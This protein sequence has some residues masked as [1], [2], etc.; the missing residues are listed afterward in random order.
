VRAWLGAWTLVVPVLVAACE[1]GP[2]P[3]AGS[4]RPQVVASFYPLAFAV[5]SVAHGRASVTDLTPAGVEP[6]D[7][8][9]TSG[10]VIAVSEADLLVYV[11]SGF[12]PAVE[13]LA[14]GM[15]DRA[16]DV[17]ASQGP[18]TVP[19]SDLAADPHV[20]LD[21]IRM[22][23]ITQ[24][25]ADRLATIDSAAAAAYRAHRDELGARLQALDREFRRGLA[26]CAQREIVTSHEAF[27]HLARRYGLRQLGIA[28]VDPGLEP[29]PQRVAKIT[30]FA[31]EHDV[32]TIFSEELV[33]PRIAET[34]A[35]ESG[36]RTDVLN[37]IE[38]RPRRGDYLDAMRANLGSLRAALR[39]R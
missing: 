34:I 27:G 22:N 11:G 39:C 4:S 35:A 15:G 37:P 29:S 23:A 9:L 25:V 30:E 28:G 6:H 21:P 13:E 38:S 19:S 31:R 12:Q 14:A 33:S 10:Q 2:S 1:P 5:E 20:W 32:T 26:R 8:E 7:I 16:V 17:L 18:D 3:S 36:I 24:L